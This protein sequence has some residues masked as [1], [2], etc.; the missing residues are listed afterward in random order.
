[1]SPRH[2]RR[3]RQ[4]QTLSALAALAR[5]SALVHEYGREQA[6]KIFV[7]G[8]VLDVEDVPGPTED[9]QKTLPLAGKARLRFTIAE[10]PKTPKYPGIVLNAGGKVVGKPMM[11]GLDEDEQI[12]AKLLKRIYG[13]VEVDELEQ[14]VTA[15]WGAVFENSKAFAEVKQWVAG[16]TRSALENTYSR[17]M[18][19][20]R[21]RLQKDINQRLEKLPQHRRGFA[22][23][24]IGR[25]L[26][27]FYGERPDRISTV[28]N[29]VLDAMERDEYWIVLQKIDHARHADVVTFSEALEQFGLLELAMMAEHA[30]HR[31]RFLDDLDALAAN[32]STHE[33]QM[34]KAIENSLW[35]LGARYQM[36]ASNGTLRRVVREY[37][38]KKYSGAKASNRPDLLL[39]A[40]SGERYLLIEFK[41]PSH[42]VDRQDEAQAREYRDELAR[43][44]P[45]KGIDIILLGGR[46]GTGA[47]TRYDTTDVRVCAYNDVIS[48]ARHE[49]HWLIKNLSGRAE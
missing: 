9:E 13:E 34:H 28:A 32:A 31:A 21:A 19:L 48:Q 35:I 22:E 47:D 40:D 20:Q 24:A 26:Q 18:N 44:F 11:F 17:E 36:M 16:E 23:E 4:A 8:S 29:V 49:L 6:F 1:M 5:D 7:N 2:C 45:A 27:K 10:G 14:H 43:H 25:V 38:D 3:P 33:Q 39:A 42:P 41:R 37:C 12:P 15:D 30:R 46:R